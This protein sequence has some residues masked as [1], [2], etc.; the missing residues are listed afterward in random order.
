M[1]LDLL[2]KYMQVDAEVDKFENEMRQSPIRQK[3]LKNRNFIMEQQANMKA[4]E[5][6][7]ADK[8]DRMEAIE[9]EAKR[10]SDL[11]TAQVES[12]KNNPPTQVEEIEKQLVGVQ[13]LLDS[14]THYEQELAR[15][16]DDAEVLDA[17]QKEIRTRAAKSKAEYDE[18]KQQYDI[19]FKRDSEELERLRKVAAKEMEGIDK[20]LTERYAAIKQHSSPPMAL[21][22]GDQCGGCHMSQPNVVLRE[23]KAGEKLVCCDNCGRILYVPAEG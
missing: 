23:I 11:V 8:N 13:K 21:M 4:I 9:A 7:I 2:W 10:L 5:A 1:Q 22:A 17:R 19:E 20:S 14:L 15:M 6:D 18:L 12:Y 16:R 3:L